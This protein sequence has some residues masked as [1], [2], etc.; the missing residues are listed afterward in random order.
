MPHTIFIVHGMGN[1]TGP[2]LGAWANQVQAALEFVYANVVQPT[3]PGQPAFANKFTVV[4][5]GYDAIFDKFTQAWA[6]SAAGWSGLTGLSDDVGRSGRSFL[7]GRL[8]RILV[9]PMPLMS[10]SM[11]CQ[12]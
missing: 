8:A 5:I 11:Q 7:V 4:P 10:Y 1:H 2:A 12:Q 9:G 3:L 6:A